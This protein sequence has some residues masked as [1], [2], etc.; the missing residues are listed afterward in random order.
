MFD[1]D[2]T[3]YSTPPNMSS[4]IDR[5]MRSFIE[6]LLDV[7]ADEAHRI[8]KSYFRE[9]GLTMRGLMLNHGVTA[10]EYQAHMERLDYSEIIADPAMAEALDRVAGR[11]VIYTNAFDRHTDIVLERLGLMD[12]FDD[13]FHIGSADYVPKPQ[14]AAYRTLCEAHDID[15]SSAVMVED[16]AHNLQPAAEIGMT[17]V[18]L[19]TSAR[20]AQGVEPEGYVHKVIEDLPGWLHGIADAQAKS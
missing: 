10:A 16:I 17:T 14:V 13:I 2:N 7:D 11:K 12:H 4:Q 1:L 5:L 9:Y 18:W 6:R 20:W 19:R 15:P 3:L 8:Q